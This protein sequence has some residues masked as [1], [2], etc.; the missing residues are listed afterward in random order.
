MTLIKKEESYNDLQPA[1]H[2]A[3]YNYNISSTTPG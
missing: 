3:V 2:I 1:E